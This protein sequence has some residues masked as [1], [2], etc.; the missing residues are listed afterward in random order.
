[1]GNRVYVWDWPLRLFHWLLLLAVAA[2]YLTQRAGAME[3]HQRIGMTIVGLIVFRLVWGF[4][5]TRHARFADFLRGPAALR[6][7]LRGE[8][9]GHGHNPLGGWSVILLL[10][11]PLGM[12]AT[13]LFANDDVS[14][15]GLLATWVDKSLSDRLTSL[16]YLGFNLLLALV[17]L[18]LAAIL[19]YRLKHRVDLVRPML[20]GWKET[21]AASGEKTE[22][23][24]TGL[25]ALALASGIAALTVAGIQALEPPPPAP[26]PA[27][28]TPD[29]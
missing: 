11:M 29:W 7:Y 15:S 18:H 6:A 4:V 2:A 14:F 9:K 8:W 20:T 22:E 13:G 27:A 10:L 21:D 28:T 24:R 3:W 19:F 5:G 17:G 12:A 26:P 16:H 23:R 25:A 1:M